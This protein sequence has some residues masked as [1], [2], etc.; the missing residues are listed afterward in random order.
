MRLNWDMAGWI[1]LFSFLFCIALAV[2][3]NNKKM[4]TVA[5]TN[6]MMPVERARALAEEQNNTGDKCAKLEKDFGIIISS[7]FANKDER[8]IIDAFIDDCYKNPLTAQQLG[9]LSRGVSIHFN[10]LNVVPHIGNACIFLP[11][12]HNWARCERVLKYLQTPTD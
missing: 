10:S 6:K 7:L 9:E 5:P 12:D 3:L 4:A 11:A 8:V 1:M 2:V